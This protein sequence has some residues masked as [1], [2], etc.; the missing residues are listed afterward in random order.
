MSPHPDTGIEVPGCLVKPGTRLAHEKWE[1]GTK[2]HL[3]SPKPPDDGRDI[4]LLTSQINNMRIH[5]QVPDSALQKQPNF[6]PSGSSQCLPSRG[7]KERSSDFHGVFLKTAW[8]LY[9]Q[10]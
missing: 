3:R 9:C 8:E 5:P 1:Q 2:L 6:R 4:D 10:Y 7:E